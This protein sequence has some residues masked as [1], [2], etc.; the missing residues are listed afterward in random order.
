MLARL[1]IRTTGTTGFDTDQSYVGCVC[2]GIKYTDGIASTADTGD[3]HIGQPT[4]LRKYL[5]ACF[6]A[7]HR[8]KVAHDARIGMRSDCG[9]DQVES[10]LH[11][12]YPV[13]NSLI[14]SIFQGTAATA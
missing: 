5:L 2:E 13:P 9:T 10:C 4:L 12:R 8:L 7:N 1:Q 14:D 11:I 6:I 3:D